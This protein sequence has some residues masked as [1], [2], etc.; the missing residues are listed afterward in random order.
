MQYFV[1]GTDE[2]DSM[3]QRIAIMERHWEFIARYDDCLIARGPV[4][5]SADVK[6]VKGSIHIV[7]LDN[8]DAAKAFAY[9]E[10]F[11]VEGVFAEIAMM[12]FRLELGRTQF[13]FEST[14]DHPRFFVHCPA[15]TEVDVVPDNVASD[16][17][18]YCREFDPHFVCRGS[19]LTAAGAWAGR[20][21]FIEMPDRAAVEG[22]LAGDPCVAAGLYDAHQIHRWTMG[23]AANLR[24]AGLMK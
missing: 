16:H 15:A 2:P 8:A 22:F 1:W 20:V 21:F 13:D 24:A 5:D 10:P 6:K 12:P 23:G 18:V 11:A 17:E 3:A 14:P 4:L 19:L 9:D 7:E